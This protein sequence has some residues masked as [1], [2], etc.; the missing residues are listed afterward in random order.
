MRGVWYVRGLQGTSSLR[1]ERA[2]KRLRLLMASKRQE[3]EE[4]AWRQYHADRTRQNM[5]RGQVWHAL[6]SPQDKGISPPRSLG[7]RQGRSPGTSAAAV[8][9]PTG[10]AGVFSLPAALH[11]ALQEKPSLRPQAEARSWQWHGQSLLCPCA[12]ARGQQHCLGH[13]AKPVQVTR[14]GRSLGSSPSSW[15]QRL[16][17]VSSAFAEPL[18]PRV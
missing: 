10:Q 16:R 17:R 5:G 4:E 1:T 8:L 15:W 11:V 2:E 6:H 9:W 12:S 18:P 14:L 7:G 3:V 13:Q